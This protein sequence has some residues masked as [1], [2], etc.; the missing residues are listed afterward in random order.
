MTV[1]MASRFSRQVW[2]ISRKNLLLMRRRRALVCFELLM[3]VFIVVLLGLVDL[4][5]TTEAPQL[6]TLATLRSDPT[7]PPIECEV[8]DSEYGF[9]GYG[10]P[11][12]SDTV[13]CVPIVFAPVTT[14]SM[15]LMREVAARNGYDEPRDRFSVSRQ[16]SAESLRRMIVGFETVD[17]LSSWL[18]EYQGRVG[19][20][21]VFG[22]STKSGKASTPVGTNGVGAVD[23]GFGSSVGEKA[24]RSWQ[25]EIW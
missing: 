23:D 15:T 12:P 8:F 24:W 9:S 7:A 19:V 22:D 18:R 2:A 14:A 5:F 17:E 1:V 3:P 20:G 10:Q 4:A 21:V 16:A 11:L 6:A 25:Y 13:W